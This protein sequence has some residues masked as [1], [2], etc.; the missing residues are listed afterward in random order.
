MPHPLIVGVGRDC[1][2]LR[3]GERAPGG[4]WAAAGQAGQLRDPNRQTPNLSLPAD[5]QGGCGQLGGAKGWDWIPSSHDPPCLQDSVRQ[6]EELKVTAA[7]LKEKY[8]AA[9][10]EMGIKVWSCELR[11]PVQWTPQMYLPTKPHK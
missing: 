4:V 3:A 5:S 8:E 2:G 9:C 10:A 1:E 7:A 11:G 6:E